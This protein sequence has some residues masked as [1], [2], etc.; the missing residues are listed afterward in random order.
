M[1]MSLD[2]ATIGVA[3]SAGTSILGGIF[4]S[5]NA[6][7]NEAAKAIKEAKLAAKRKAYLTN[8]TG[9][10]KTIRITSY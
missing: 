1:E 3:V 9:N 4:G 7:K 8:T 6:K 2:P 10:L 5:N